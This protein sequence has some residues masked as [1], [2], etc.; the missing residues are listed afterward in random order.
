M[1]KPVRHEQEGAMQGR[2]QLY[3]GSNVPRGRR[4]RTKVSVR[5]E[6]YW[7]SPGVHGLVKWAWRREW[8]KAETEGKEGTKDGRDTAEGGWAHL[9]RGTHS[10]KE[11]KTQ[12]Y[13]RKHVA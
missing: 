10:P 4:K 3:S 12:R 1:P 7:R 8:Y 9:A 13:A 5:Q 6:R 2:Q 11:R